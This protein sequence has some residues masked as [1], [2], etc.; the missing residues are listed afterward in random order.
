MLASAIHHE[1]ASGIHVFSPSWILLPPPTPSSPSRLSQSTALSSLCH[2]ANSDL[3][4]ILHMEMYVSVLFFQ[5]VPPSPSPTVSTH[6]FSVS[7]QCFLLS[8]HY[9][10]LSDIYCFLFTPSKLQPGPWINNQ[11]ATRFW[12]LQIKPKKKKKIQ[13]CTEPFLLKP[14]KHCLFIITIFKIS[15][16]YLIADLES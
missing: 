11:S 7:L 10:T 5:F 14:S 8:P 12:I 9:R 13:N 3:L 15:Y 4:S 1:S 2:T 16:R 6:L